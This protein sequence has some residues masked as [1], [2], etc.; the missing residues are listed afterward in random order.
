[1][2]DEPSATPGFP[3]QRLGER[4]SYCVIAVVLVATAITTVRIRLQWSLLHILIAGLLDVSVAALY[5][6]TASTTKPAD[7]GILAIV[8][9]LIAL[10]HLGDVWNPPSYRNQWSGYID[11]IPF[12]MEA[13]GCVFIW[14]ALF[15][16]K[17]AFKRI[18]KLFSRD[19]GDSF[20]KR[21][22]ALVP[23]VLGGLAI[24]GAVYVFNLPFKKAEAL[25]ETIKTGMSAVDVVNIVEDNPYHGHGG[26]NYHCFVVQDHYGDIGNISEFPAEIE[27]AMKSSAPEA[28]WR[29]DIY[30]EYITPA[31]DV[32]YTFIVRF[33]R[34]GKAAAVTPGAKLSRTA[35]F[36]QDR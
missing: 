9:A 29:A 35:L 14:S 4:L 24:Y 5:F 17:A 33:G 28:P 22:A 15:A 34:D 27:R 21:S 20:S 36:C 7:P 1:M 16:L 13:F 23:V 2:P 11:S 31:P 25:R 32:H 19:P 26:G 3:L 12:V 10:I 6:W 18:A 30:A 8:G